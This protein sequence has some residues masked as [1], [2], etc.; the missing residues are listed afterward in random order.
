MKPREAVIAT[1]ACPRCGAA[2][3]VD[4]YHGAGIYRASKRN[5]SE[6][7]RAA[8]EAAVQSIAKGVP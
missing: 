2:R 4:C 7:V 1:V 3:G 5:H 6:R 8:I